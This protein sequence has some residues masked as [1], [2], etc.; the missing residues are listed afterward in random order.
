[1]RPRIC[2]GARADAHR[3]C[4]PAVRSG[5]AFAGSRP[6][7]LLRGGGPGYEVFRGTTSAGGWACKASLSR[8]CRLTKKRNFTL[9]ENLRGGVA[10]RRRST[11]LVASIL[12]TSRG[13]L[14]RNTSAIGV[15][16]VN[17]MWLES[18]PERHGFHFFHSR[19]IHY[20]RLEKGCHDV[21]RFRER[22]C[23]DLIWR[24]GIEPRS[25]TGR[26]WC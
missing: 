9:R 3:D 10:R 19:T 13:N 20:K 26:S 25:R 23:F 4:Q 11:S 7:D 21:M 16:Y 22:F 18:L 6:R 2:T 24:H 1:L 5:G 8:R 12:P 14:W 15:P 17:A